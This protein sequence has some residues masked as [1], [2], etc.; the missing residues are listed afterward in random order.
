[1]WLPFTRTRGLRRLG[2]IKNAD[3]ALKS[4][5]LQYSSKH[6]QKKKKKLRLRSRCRSSNY[7][8]CEAGQL[9]IVSEMEQEAAVIAVE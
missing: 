8:F 2:H 9:E 5:V 1:M 6:A 4:K 3:L 7:N